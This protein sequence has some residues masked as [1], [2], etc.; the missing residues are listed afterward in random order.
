MAG[1]AKTASPS[2]A[3]HT[4]R[5]LLAKGFMTRFSAA[6]GSAVDPDRQMAGGG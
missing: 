3:P 6:G 4:I 2:R 1:E 5:N